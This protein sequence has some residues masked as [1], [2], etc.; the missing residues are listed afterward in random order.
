MPATIVS[1]QQSALKTYEDNGD[2]TGALHVIMDSAAPSSGTGTVSAAAVTDTV[3]VVLAANANRKTAV[4]YNVGPNTAYLGGAAVADTDGLPLP[5]GASFEDDQ[6][7]D[8]W[9]AICAAGET[10]SLRIWEVE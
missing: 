5:M 1:P 2:Q 3:G 4:F 9:S 8:E 6:T 10:A 7:A